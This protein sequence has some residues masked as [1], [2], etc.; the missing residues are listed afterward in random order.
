M[1]LKTG[2]VK[3]KA[4]LSRTGL[5]KVSFGLSDKGKDL[6]EDVKYVSPFG[7]A[8]EGWVAIPP[9]GARVLVCHEPNV[10]NLGDEFRGYFYLGS[11]MGAITGVNQ[12]SPTDPEEANK[13][14]P[15]TDYVP[16]TKPGQHGPPLGTNQVA[17][18]KESEAGWL[19]ERFRD[20]Y[21]AKGIIPE[22]MGFSNHRGDAFK[23]SDRSNNSSKSSDP[24]QD[25]AIGLMSGSGKRLQLVDS[26]IV[27]GMVYSNEHRGKDFFIWSSGSS[28][29][30]PFAE[31][32]YHMRT[33]G[34]VNLYTLWNRFHIWVEDGLNIEIEN[35]STPSKSY[36]PGANAGPK[37]G[38]LPN[39]GMGGYESTRKRVYGNE[40]TGCVQILSHW[41]NISTI[42]LGDDSVIYIEAPGPNSKVII[43]T[44]GTCDIRS[45]GKLTLQ[46]DTQVEINSPQ[47]TINGS[48]EVDINGGVVYIDGGDVRLN[49]APGGGDYTA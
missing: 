4:D 12:Q 33:H 48:S 40:T 38:G 25:F 14:T 41:N 11:I 19:P 22:V 36:G 49:D 32:E 23:I 39:G 30:S 1:Q 24:F 6:L 27:D 9:V 42:A 20:M 43:D 44:E 18:I 34:P 35:K 7:N 2:T 3:S 17:Q 28:P 13:Q 31:G 16:K 47:V 5:F 21:D 26:P 15:N 45:K 29:E 37:G 8:T 46:S 10:A